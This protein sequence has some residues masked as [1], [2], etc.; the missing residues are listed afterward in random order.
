MIYT[1]KTINERWGKWSKTIRKWTGKELGK[2]NWKYI[3]RSW[4]KNRCE[5]ICDKRTLKAGYSIWLLEC[6]IMLNLS[7][8]CF[9]LFYHNLN[10]MFTQRMM[11]IQKG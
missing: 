11:F 2:G 3:M 7:W 5:G 10:I 1:K 8:N 6:L 4:S 9:V